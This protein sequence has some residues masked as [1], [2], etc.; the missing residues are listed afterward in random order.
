MFSI[1]DATGIKTM[2]INSGVSHDARGYYFRRNVFLLGGEAL[3]V[4]SDGITS[5]IESVQFRFVIGDPLLDDFL[6]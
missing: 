5:L 6:G 4:C 3:G 2:N 1:Y